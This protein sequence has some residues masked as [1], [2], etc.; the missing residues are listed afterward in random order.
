MHTI[1][2]RKFRPLEFLVASTD[3]ITDDYIGEFIK[4]HNLN[5]LACKNIIGL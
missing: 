1:I 4:L 2:F 5:F 3:F